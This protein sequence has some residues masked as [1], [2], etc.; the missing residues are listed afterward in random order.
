MTPR[1]IDADLETLLRSA[2]PLPDAATLA[3]ETDRAVSRTRAAVT[4]EGRSAS[5][6][7][8][9]WTTHQAPW[10]TI[11]LAVTREGLAGISL[12]E[13]TEVFV[14]DLERRLQ[15]IVA[16]DGPD[17]PLEWH[18]LLERTKAELD[19]YFAGRRTAFDLTV[20]LRGMSDWDRRVLLGARGLPFGAVTSYG[21][22]ARLIDRPGA[23][24]AVGGALGRNPVPIVIP[25]HRIVAGDGTIG[26]YGGSW[27]GVGDMLAIKRTLLAIEGVRLPAATLLG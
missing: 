7:V 17:L 24:R 13:P 23:A 4:A 27:S 14:H 20:D 16:P 21:R 2:D 26:G 19:E 8:A 3:A 25:C 11:H 12:R 6:P 18:A 5:A 1:P 9:A 10:G 22:L 15:G